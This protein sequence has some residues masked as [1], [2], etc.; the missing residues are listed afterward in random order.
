MCKAPLVLGLEL[1]HQHFYHIL[2]AKA[3]QRLAHSQNRE[4]FKIPGQI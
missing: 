3:S 4:D 2:S 1:A